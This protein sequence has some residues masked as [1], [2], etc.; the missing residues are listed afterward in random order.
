MPPS[1]W[2]LDGSSFA[3]GDLSERTR[4][5]GYG[6]YLRGQ[7]INVDS[8]DLVQRFHVYGA[9]PKYLRSLTR[10]S[11]MHHASTVL[12][13]RRV[14]WGGCRFIKPP[15]MFDGST[16]LPYSLAYYYYCPSSPR[17]PVRRLSFVSD[18]LFQ[19][20]GSFIENLEIS[21]I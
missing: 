17:L 3:E 18:L 13:L 16:N 4:Q 5:E 9:V 12:L 21:D 10:S 1:R 6:R 15:G 19:H 14:S 7:R 8:P 20:T 11:A 2:I